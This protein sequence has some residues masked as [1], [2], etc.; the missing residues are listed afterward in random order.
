[1]IITAEITGIKYTPK[2]GRELRTHLLS[3]LQN[4]LL[5][6]AS[7]LLKMN[8]GNTIAVSW[9][10]SSKR[11][12]SY[13][14]ARVYDTLSFPS[15][16]V[17][18]IP[19]F[20]DEGFDGDRD[21][22]Q[23]DTVSLMSLLGVYVIIAYYIS[24]SPNPN[25]KNKITDQRFDVN[26]LLSQINELLSYQSDALHWNLSQIDRAG[27]LAEKALVSYMTISRK[28]GIRMHS[29]RSAERRISELLKGKEV[30]MALSRKLAEKAQLRE[31]VT[32]Q[33]KEK[34]SGNKASITI[35]NYLG[36]YYF[37]TVDEAR[38]EDGK[39]LLIEGKH[40]RTSHLPSLGDIKDG[41]L[42][43]ILFTN[44]QNVEV[45]SKR[46]SPVPILLLL[47]TGFELKVEN[48]ASDES[49]RQLREEA[50]VNNFKIMLNNKIVKL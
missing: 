44:L 33:P 1:M 24:A 6:D 32:R 29:S 9:W 20:K 14:Y 19:I 17:T 4:A 46:A 36:G 23:W 21:F 34:L 7:F 43:M 25:Y 28:L 15:K 38:R 3:S 40:T 5:S 47:T 12:R 39:V 35:K 8:G 41:L 22:L 37:F 13:P 18:I 48:L 45:D 50:R 49:F 16:K 30:F 10:V 27:E 2:L 11:T 31:I 26:Y 42:R